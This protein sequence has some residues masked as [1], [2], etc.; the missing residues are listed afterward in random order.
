MPG[1]KMKGALA[2]AVATATVGCALI[3]ASGEG[4]SGRA[5]A[6][7]GLELIAGGFASPV[8]LV[9]SRDGTGRLFVVDQVGVIRVVT[10]EGLRG[11]PFLDLRPRL[12]ELNPDFDERG[13]LG[14]AFHPAF[15][16]NGRFFLYYSAPLR[17][18]APGGWDHTSRIAEFRVRRD[19][20]DRADPESERILLEV[21]QPQSNHNA[22]QIA[23]GPDGYLYIPLGDG[24]RGSDT[25]TGHPL[26]G[27]GQ[28][29]STLLG[30]ILRLDVDGTGPYG[31][32]PD[33]PLVGREGHDEIFA[34]GLRNPFRISFDAGGDHELFAADVGQNLWEEVNIITG[35][36][37]YGWNVREGAHCFDPGRPDR[38]PERCAG[39]DA[40]G[41]PLI[42]PII[43]YGNAKSP[44][45]IGTAVI[46][47][48]VYRGSA[49]TGF[50]GDYIFADFSASRR[51]PDGRLFAA[52]RPP[53]G[54]G[55]WSIRE[56][57]VA[58][59]ASG[60]IEAYVR[61][62]GQD[63]N[64]ELYVLT[65]EVGGPAGNTGRVYRIVP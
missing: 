59:N 41:R 64:N 6:G 62:F 38:S 58:T 28:D 50:D 54:G 47:G 45:G 26:T 40:R 24:G 63:V 1:S 57:R 48:F 21:D 46:G 23:F 20:P 55:M 52:T 18:T 8:G 35:G 9:P 34:F 19:D 14:M 32:P 2:L 7:V 13:L 36:G 3:T 17:A 15:R 22:G 11:E 29:T 39:V 43:E 4:A 56:L 60:R 65:A 31:V 42:D 16:D 61:S 25:G 33:N 12:V 53:A 27:N 10:G 44:G 5:Q 30:S 49:L 37:N 51:R